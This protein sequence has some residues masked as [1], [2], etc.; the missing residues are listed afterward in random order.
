MEFF[1]FIVKIFGGNGCVCWAWKWGGL[2]RFR[3]SYNVSP[4]SYMPVLRSDDGSSDGVAVHCMKWGLVPSFTK[5]GEKPDHFRMV[6]FFVYICLRSFFSLQSFIDICYRWCWW[7]QSLFVCVYFC[8]CHE[9]S[10][11]I[12]S[13]S[14]KRKKKKKHR[15]LWGG[16]LVILSK[17]LIYLGT[18]RRILLIYLFPWIL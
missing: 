8:F 18:I 2:C 5:K 6:F 12:A 9:V 11:Y 7:R 16:G 17:A 1:F 10:V 13:F 3:P 4:G 15:F 14:R